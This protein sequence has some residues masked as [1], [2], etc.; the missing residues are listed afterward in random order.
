ME[1]KE[2]KAKILLVDDDDSILESLNEIL[3][4]EGYETKSAQTGKEA[5]EACQKDSFDVAL[6]DIKLPDMV[7]TA[8]LAILKKFNPMLGIIIVTGYQTDT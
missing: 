2:S 4:Q 8:L 6:I 5:I 7:G 1:N 3:T